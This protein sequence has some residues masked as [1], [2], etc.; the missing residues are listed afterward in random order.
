MLLSPKSCAKKSNISFLQAPNLNERG[1][2][3]LK[4]HIWHI[5]TDWTQ[6]FSSVLERPCLGNNE[7]NKNHINH[8]SI[9]NTHKQACGCSPLSPGPNAVWAAELQ[10]FLM[11]ELIAASVY[12]A[13]ETKTR[14]KLK[15]TTHMYHQQALGKCLYW[16]ARSV[17]RKK[18]CCFWACS[19]K[20]FFFFFLSFF[21]G[22]L[23][24]K[25]KSKLY[26]FSQCVSSA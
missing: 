12:F 16:L 9:N 21:F 25:K 18:L 10:C 20:F 24:P 2:G 23:F 6:C 13:K 5:S 22:V 3:T 4:R 26:H 8:E 7:N 15:K 17:A 14:Y 19:I 1:K 11:Q